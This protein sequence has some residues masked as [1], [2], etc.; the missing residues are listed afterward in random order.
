MI[1]IP[2]GTVH[3]IGAGIKLIEVQQSSDVTY[4]LYDWGRKRELHIEKSVQVINYEGDNGYGKIEN[5]EVLETPYF[6]VQKV[7][8]DGLLQGKTQDK[9]CSF[10][11][12][13]GNGYVVSY[14]KR[15]ELNPEETVYI[16]PNTKYEII[17]EMEL[18]KA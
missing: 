11:V 9:F 4:R 8:V 5:F 15:I 10:T 2:S 17:G 12:I 18:I 3:A 13:R 7:K 1:Y 6:K 16:E 14:D